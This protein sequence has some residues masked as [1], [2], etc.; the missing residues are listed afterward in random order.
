LSQKKVV[1]GLDKLKKYKDLTEKYFS[2][3]EEFEIYSISKRDNDETFLKDTLEDCLVMNSIFFIILLIIFFFTTDILGFFLISALV[4]FP[5]V[6]FCSNEFFMQMKKNKKNI[7]SKKM[8]K[9]IIW[10]QNLNCLCLPLPFLYP[11]YLIP[12]LL[13]IKKRD[14]IS[15]L[16]FENTKRQKKEKLNIIEK[17]KN[18]LLEN[19]MKDEISLNKIKE[20]EQYLE[21][22]KDVEHIIKKL[23]V[24]DLDLIDLYILQTENE[25]LKIEN[26]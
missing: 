14:K 4:F 15:K 23:Y 18:K 11:L 8:L 19:I 9:K 21:I 2:E 5:Y 24:K 12:E 20:D 10:I 6:I 13:K 1:I 25:N 16:D 17:E 22:K 26:I 7:K 3:K